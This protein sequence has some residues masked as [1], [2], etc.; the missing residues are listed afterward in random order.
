MSV[1]T[2]QPNAK[3]WRKS[4]KSIVFLRASLTEPAYLHQLIAFKGRVFE[5]NVF[6][7]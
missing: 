4:L 6:Y 5:S 3:V 2:L 1:A 7:S